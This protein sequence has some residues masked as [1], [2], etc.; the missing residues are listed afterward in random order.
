MKLSYDVIDPTPDTNPRLPPIIFLH[1]MIETRKTWKKVA[2]AI[3]RKTRRKAY[4]PDARSHGKSPTTLEMD[5]EVMT[6]DVVE[7]MDQLNIRKATIVGHSMGGRTAINFALK[8]PHRVD[9]LVIEDMTPKDV[10]SK[11]GVLHF[12]LEA[13]EDFAKNLPQDVDE[14]EGKNIVLE[15]LL[16]FLGG[17]ADKEKF[18]NGLE[19]DM[20]PIKKVG[21]EFFGD[22]DH[23]AVRKL[24]ETNALVQNLPNQNLRFQGDALFM[25]GTRPFFNLGKDTSIPKL[26]PRAILKRVQGASH[27]IHIDSFNAYI[28]IVSDFILHRN[29]HPSKY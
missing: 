22:C 15:T 16:S 27:H 14:E 3:A 25:Y 19:P 23:E 5:Y 7:F 12:A 18:L 9:V 6:Q 4:L 11:D 20:L 2:P 17:Y 21:K 26:F 10:Y 29:L 1:G 24:V 28:D 8:Y 13:I